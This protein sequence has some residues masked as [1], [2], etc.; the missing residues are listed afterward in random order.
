[1]NVIFDKK[2]DISDDLKEQTDNS[3]LS[4]YYVIT[5]LHTIL[6]P[7]LLRRVKTEVAKELPL[8]KEYIVYAPL[9]NRQ[10]ELYAAALKGTSGLR[11]VIAAQ[12]QANFGGGGDVLPVDKVEDV[13]EEDV[14]VVGEVM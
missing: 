3:V 1:M 9:T 2:F 13:A 10:K 11:D 14:W 8:K 4:K 5:N 6:K 7:F 12:N